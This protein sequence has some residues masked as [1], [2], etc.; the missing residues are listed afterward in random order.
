MLR[1]LGGLLAERTKQG[2][3]IVLSGILEEQAEEMNGIYAEW[4]E[5][6]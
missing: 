5:S 4:F 1:M 2:G 6:V 3:R